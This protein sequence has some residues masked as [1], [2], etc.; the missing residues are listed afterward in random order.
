MCTIPAGS[1]RD[2]LHKCVGISSIVT[3]PLGCAMTPCSSS[4]PHAAHRRPKGIVD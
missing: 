3:K 2:F 1:Y 4:P